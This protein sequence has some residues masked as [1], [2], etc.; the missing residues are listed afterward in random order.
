M[1]DVSGVRVGWG[2]LGSAWTMERM[3]A[4]GLHAWV[5]GLRLVRERALVTDQA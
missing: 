5:K 1:C 3:D 2:V 4:Y